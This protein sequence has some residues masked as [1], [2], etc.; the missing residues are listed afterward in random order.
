MA[1]PLLIAGGLMAAGQA[2]QIYGNIQANKKQAELERENARYLEEQAGF[3][4]E[5]MRRSLNIFDEESEQLLG[6]Q[7]SAYSRGGVAL[8]GSALAVFADT[9]GKQITE[10]EGIRLDFEAKEKEALLKAGASYRQA[11]YLSNWKTNFLPAAGASANT[12]A[13]ILAMNSKGS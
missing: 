13:S 10:R 5:A 4:R 2:L 9:L 11:Q 7:V 8:S 1:A 3:T 12:G 6:S